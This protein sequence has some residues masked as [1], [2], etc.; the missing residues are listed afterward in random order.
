MFLHVWPFPIS[1]G[2]H[3]GPEYEGTASNGVEELS[4]DAVVEHSAS[5]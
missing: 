3:R 5:V 4:L 1:D 2:K